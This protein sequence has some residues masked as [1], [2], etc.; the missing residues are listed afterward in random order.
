VST[1]FVANNAEVYQQ[2]MGRWS[3]RLAIN[4]TDFAS[5]GGPNSIL[6]VGC[7]TASLTVALAKHFPGAKITGVDFSQA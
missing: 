2:H 5:V 4:F 3:Q 7:G 1:I 6:D